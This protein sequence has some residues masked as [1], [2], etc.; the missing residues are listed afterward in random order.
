ML[1]PRMMTLPAAVVRPN[2]IKP[3]FL[4]D[5][6]GYLLGADGKGNSKRSQECFLASG[7]FHHQILDGVDSPAA[8]A[9]LA[10][11]DTWQP[12]LAETHP[13]L[14]GCWAELMKGSNL[15]FPGGRAVR[16]G[17]PQNSSRLGG[18][19]SPDGRPGGPVSGHRPARGKPRPSTHPS[20]ASA[21]PSPAAQP[22]FLST[23]PLSA[24]TEKRRA[25]MRRWGNP[26]P[27]PTPPP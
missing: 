16:P 10:Y 21:A 6:S 24:P 9:V 12:E 26:P 20:K 22:L 18:P 15:V 13:A 5:N 14:A 25:T 4:W 27:L 1:R 19:L 2:T 8:K 23:P 3:N 11:F 7:A 17:R